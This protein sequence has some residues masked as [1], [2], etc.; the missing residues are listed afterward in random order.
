[1]I[2]D[3]IG[4]F[5]AQGVVFNIE[6]IKVGLGQSLCKSKEEFETMRDKL[7]QYLDDSS[8]T[9]MYDL[10]CVMLTNPNGT[11]SYVLVSGRKKYLFKFIARLR[12]G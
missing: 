11:G 12:I 1:M 7:Q 10:L 9:G 8:K 6:G 2:G 4:K 3:N 5:M